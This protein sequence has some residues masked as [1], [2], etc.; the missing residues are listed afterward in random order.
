M[1]EYSTEYLQYWS[2]EWIARWSES[3][4]ALENIARGTLQYLKIYANWD[5][6]SGLSKIPSYRYRAERIFGVEWTPYEADGTIKYEVSCGFGELAMLEREWARDRLEKFEE[7]YWPNELIAEG[8]FM[9][10]CI[11][12]TLFKMVLWIDWV[13]QRWDSIVDEVERLL[14]ARS[15]REAIIEE[16]LERSA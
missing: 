9:C 6:C 3:H 16:E 2:D 1:S 7:R 4:W 14:M 15:E 13:E 5:V 12:G 10:G 8:Q 11:S